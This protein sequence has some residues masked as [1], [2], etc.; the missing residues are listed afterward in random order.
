VYTFIIESGI[1][2]PLIWPVSYR[3]PLVWRYNPLWNV[4][5]YWHCCTCT[6]GLLL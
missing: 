3:L 1:L 6:I 2:F 4:P 5:F